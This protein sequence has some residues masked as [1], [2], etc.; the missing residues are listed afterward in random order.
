MSNTITLDS[1]QY[2]GGDDVRVTLQRPDPDFAG[3]L[4]WYVARRDESGTV[5]YADQGSI[6]PISASDEDLAFTFTP[7]GAG[8]YLLTVVWQPKGAQA[9]PFADWE[10]FEVVAEEARAV[11]GGGDVF[12]GIGPVH[13]VQLT[14]RRPRGGQDGPYATFSDFLGFLSAGNSPFANPAGLDTFEQGQSFVGLM[15]AA[16]DYVADITCGRFEDLARPYLQDRLDAE[17]LKMPGL[18]DAGGVLD[19]D[20]V[21][22]VVPCVELIWNYW[23]EEGMLVQTLNL[24]LARFQNR[25]VPGYTALNRFDVSPLVSLQALL[26]DFVDEEQH[27]MTLRRRALQYEYEYGLRLIGKAVPSPQVPL[28]RRTGFL[29]AFHQVLYLA[30]VFFKEH[31]DMTVQADP[32]PL[33]Q[34]LREAHLI[35][36]AGSHNQYGQM[37]IRARAEF[38]AM[39]YLL[40]LPQMREF[41]GGRPMTPYPEEWQDRVDTMKSLQPGWPDASVMHFFDLATIGER[42]V[43]TIRLGNWTGVTVGGDEAASWALIFREGIQKYVAAYRAVTGVDLSHVADATMPS[44]LIAR[45]LDEQPR[46]A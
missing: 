29:A 28:E 6:K 34:A 37:A 33:Y 17:D 35:L 2:R 46:R 7:P 31:D 42:L 26:Y 38:V 24:I 3:A 20:A 11:L 19:P 18:V 39:Q 25:V 43:L 8:R 22:R 27:R 41:L 21:H 40:A 12:G 14:K 15:T 45:R 44:T 4:H 30:H 5:Q 16:R 10:E 36:S 23:L 32:F 13:L 9:T 1:P